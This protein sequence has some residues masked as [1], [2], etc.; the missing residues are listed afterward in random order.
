MTRKTSR[1]RCSCE[2]KKKKKKKTEDRVSR[3]CWFMAYNY[4]HNHN[5]HSTPHSLIGVHVLTTPSERFFRLVFCF[6]HFLAL[7]WWVM[8]LLHPVT[9]EKEMTDWYTD[10]WMQGWTSF[11][12]SFL[13]SFF[14]S[15]FLSFFLSSSPFHF[16]TFKINTNPT[17]CKYRCAMNACFSSVIPL[18]FTLLWSRCHRHRNDSPCWD[19]VSSS[20]QIWML[21][22]L[23]E[24]HSQSEL[25]MINNPTR[26]I[27]LGETEA[28]DLREWVTAMS[29]L[30]GLSQIGNHTPRKH[31]MFIC[32]GLCRLFP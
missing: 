9:P 16:H 1:R 24:H 13:L 15:S 12:L 11:F 25:A 29:P 3:S 5:C 32:S 2:K 17:K 28:R 22:P 4:R 23:A 6:F 10:R 27:W 14:L 21:N 8:I 18:L 31:E 26:E 19:S 30:S 20:Q 7:V